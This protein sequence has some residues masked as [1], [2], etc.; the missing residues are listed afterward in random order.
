RDGADRAQDAPALPRVHARGAPR[1][2]SAQGAPGSA[3]RGGTPRRATL[4]AHLLRRVPRLGHRRCD[5]PRPPAARALLAWRDLRDD[6]QLRYIGPVSRLT[7][8]RIYT[9]HT[10]R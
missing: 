6:V 4:P 2:R 5:D 3:R 1:A 8:D 9:C 7:Y 10:V